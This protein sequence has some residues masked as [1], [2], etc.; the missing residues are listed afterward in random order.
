[1]KRGLI[2]ILSLFITFGCE[3]KF[4]SGK[5]Y[6]E[7][8]VTLQDDG[9]VK[10]EYYLFRYTDLNCQR[11]MNAKRRTLRYQ[12]DDQSEYV[13]FEFS[14]FPA[15]TDHSGGAIEVKITYMVGGRSVS[16]MI[17]V[18]ILKSEG[19]KYWF[20]SMENR[21]GIIADFQAIIPIPEISCC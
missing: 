5:E 4:K 16:Y 8:F 17:P 21:M 6:A 3:E 19:S 20:W 10:G 12:N 2:I 13:N 18:V 14:S 7:K 11:V 15:M 9:L 1:M